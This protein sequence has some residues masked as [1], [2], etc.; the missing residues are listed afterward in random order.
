MCVR[1]CV[2]AWLQH[3]QEGHAGGSGVYRGDYRWQV[4]GCA[5]TC[6]EPIVIDGEIQVH[7][8]VTH[9]GSPL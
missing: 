8:P 5:E 2:V 4:A 9:S 1:G 6:F 3:Q 7:V